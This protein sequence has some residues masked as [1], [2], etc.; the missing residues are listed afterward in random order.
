MK[1]EFYIKLTIQQLWIVITIGATIVGS[2]FGIGYKFATEV[3]KV[4]KA[5]LEQEYMK[6]ISD[7]NNKHEDNI[8][9]ITEE[10]IEVK[11]KNKINY[12]NSIYY[13]NRYKFY[14]EKYEK[15]TFFFNFFVGEEEKEE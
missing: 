10:L 15:S 8:L 9:K 13:Q 3:G 4:E 11:R 1:K 14:K 6:L 2:S 12:E 7:I 5:R